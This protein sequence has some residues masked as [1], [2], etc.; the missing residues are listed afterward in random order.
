LRSSLRKAKKEDGFLPRR[1]TEN[2]DLGMPKSQTC[3]GGRGNSRGKFKKGQERSN[4]NLAGK[5]DYDVGINKMNFTEKN[6]GGTSEKTSATRK[7]NF[8]EAWISKKRVG[9]STKGGRVVNGRR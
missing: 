4:N 2:M 3:G 5:K 7:I 1:L 8:D 6:G 9:R